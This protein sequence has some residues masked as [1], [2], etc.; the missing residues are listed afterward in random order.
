MIL[1]HT[2]QKTSSNPTMVG[3]WEKTTGAIL[4]LR[5]RLSHHLLRIPRRVWRTRVPTVSISSLKLLL[6]LSE[7]MVQTTVTSTPL[8]F[9]T[10][11][12]PVPPTL[13]RKS[14]S[15]LVW[16]FASNLVPKSSSALFSKTRG[17]LVRTRPKHKQTCKPTARLPT[18]ARSKPVTKASR[19][20][21]VYDVTKRPSMAK[22]TGS[23][24]SR[25]A[26]NTTNP[27]IGSKILSGTV[28]RLTR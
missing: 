9:L 15:N 4:L 8:P 22:N 10:L 23:A 11:P 27:S 19:T 24:P 14:R 20:R 13:G 25:V 18:V 21:A 6:V 2:R 7:A 1:R 12:Y 3:A 5:T 26:R 28:A 17:N 16:R